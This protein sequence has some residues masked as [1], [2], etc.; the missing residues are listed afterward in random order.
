MEFDQAP[1]TQKV[2]RKLTW[3]WK[4][5]LSET[6]RCQMRLT[7]RIALFLTANVVIGQRLITQNP[8]QAGTIVS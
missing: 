2:D 8:N 1:K 3:C 4:P 7:K 6:L 5:S